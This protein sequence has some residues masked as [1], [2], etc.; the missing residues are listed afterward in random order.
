MRRVIIIIS[1]LIIAV[2]S[3]LAFS[4]IPFDKEEAWNTFEDANKLYLQKQYK[5]AASYYEKLIA[6]GY[7][8]PTVYFNLSNA[9]MFSER[10]GKAALNL[11]R[12]RRLQPRRG[13]IQ[14]NLV[15]LK[16]MTV[17]RS[18]SGEALEEKEPGDILSP[19]EFVNS[20]SFISKNEMAIIIFLLYLLFFI[21]SLI[22]KLITSKALKF[23]TGT[24]AAVAYLAT[25]FLIVIFTSTLYFEYFYPETIVMKT[26]ELKTSPAE[27]E[28]YKAGI[29]LKEGALVELKKTYNGW[30]EIIINADEKTGW[31]RLEHL[32]KI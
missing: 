1:A 22:R 18:T 20:F 8:D 19:K 14:K 23:L 26:V 11:H 15:V 31:I 2:S 3:G 24:A 21:W 32:E 25:L 9:Y 29:M 16:S 4:A 6:M 7:N 10:P 27:D 28:S 12:A 5:E 30:G 17:L 13:D